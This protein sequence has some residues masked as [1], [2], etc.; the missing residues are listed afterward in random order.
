MTFAEKALDLGFYSL[1]SNDNSMQST[2]LTVRLYLSANYSELFLF[3]N[4][5]HCSPTVFKRSPMFAN[6]RQGF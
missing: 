6:V 3:T 2:T 1:F 4:V 5:R